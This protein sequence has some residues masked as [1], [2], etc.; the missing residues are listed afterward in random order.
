LDP[1]P[2]PLVRIWGSGSGSATKCHGSPTLRKRLPVGVIVKGVRAGLFVTKRAGRQSQNEN[3]NLQ[4]FKAESEK[5]H[6]L[7]EKEA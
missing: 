2:D 4:D 3:F 7:I 5:V 1:D 6:S